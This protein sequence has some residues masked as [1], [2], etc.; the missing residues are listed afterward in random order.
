MAR[1]SGT[2]LA[3]SSTTAKPKNQMFCPLKYTQRAIKY[4]APAR[5]K[6]RQLYRVPSKILAKKA[7]YITVSSTGETRACSQGQ[8]SRAVLLQKTTVNS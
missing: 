6:L 1:R 8:C 4:N 3:A 2:S 5:P 7:R